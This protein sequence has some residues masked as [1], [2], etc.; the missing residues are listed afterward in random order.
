MYTNV[1][2]ANPVIQG[3]M[4]IFGMK[5]VCGGSRFHRGI[6]FLT[7][8][9]FGLLGTHQTRIIAYLKTSGIPNSSERKRLN[10]I[11]S[12]PEINESISWIFSSFEDLLFSPFIALFEVFI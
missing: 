3:Y 6:Q 11:R 7:S 12:I 4:D 1:R 10:P 8:V 2:E 5:Q 9:T